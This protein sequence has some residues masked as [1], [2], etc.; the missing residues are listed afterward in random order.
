MET[1]IFSPKSEKL[2]KLN[3]NGKIQVALVSQEPTLYAGSIREN[4]LYGCEDLHLGEEG[5]EDRGVGESEM[6]DAAKLANIH[7][8]VTEETESGYDTGCGERGVQLSG[9]F[10]LKS[11]ESSSNHNEIKNSTLLPI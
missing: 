11:I 9:G 5:S 7:T 1:H 10:M 6:V 3:K 4:I 2:K 8:F